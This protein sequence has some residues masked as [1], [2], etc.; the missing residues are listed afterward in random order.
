MRSATAYA[1]G[2]V[3]NVGPGFDVLGLAVEGVG[4][5]VTV[6][7]AEKSRVTV[8]GRDAA[9]VPTEPESNCAAIAAVRSGPARKWSSPAAT[10]S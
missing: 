5:R 8:R 6:E 2:S 3:G 4:D 7:L 1:P 10:T 9:L